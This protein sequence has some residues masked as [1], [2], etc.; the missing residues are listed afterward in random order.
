MGEDTPAVPAKNVD[1][2][3]MSPKMVAHKWKKGQSGNPKGRPKGTTKLNKLIDIKIREAAKLELSSKPR[4]YLQ[5]K[6]ESITREIVKIALSDAEEFPIKDRS[7][8]I[9]GVERK[10][11]KGKLK[12]LI[13]CF[14][15]I[16]P[17]LKV[18]DIPKVDDK[19]V[20]EMTDE[21]IIGMMERMIH[22]TQQGE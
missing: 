5:G 18:V 12:C 8:N 22:L 9:I 10:Y 6:A 3:G 21:E 16:I 4:S 17:T 13:A 14:D 20:T 11:G 19:N 7:G 15:R 2:K 1:E